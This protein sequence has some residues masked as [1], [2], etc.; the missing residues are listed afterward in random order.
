LSRFDITNTDDVTHNSNELN[1]QQ[2]LAANMDRFQSDVH[3]DV[4]V[5]SEPV[6]VVD[7]PTAFTDEG[8]SSSS[9]NHVS[10]TDDGQQL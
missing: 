3:C 10:T 4:I 9:T 6:N 2:L 7:W 8:N 5:N 1:G